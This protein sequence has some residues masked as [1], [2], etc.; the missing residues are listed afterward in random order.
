MKPDLI[1]DADSQTETAHAVDPAPVSRALPNP[2]SE[3]TITVNR[4]AAILG[5]SRRHAYAAVEQGEIPSIAVGRRIVIPTA[6]FLAK[7]NLAVETHEAP[8]AA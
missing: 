1:A 5:I 3:P 2:F 7:F 4:V 8:A 6:R